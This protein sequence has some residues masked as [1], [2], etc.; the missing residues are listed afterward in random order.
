[1]YYLTDDDLRRTQ[2]DNQRLQEVAILGQP[3][4]VAVVEVVHTSQNADYNLKLYCEGWEMWMTATI[5]WRHTYDVSGHHTWNL[6]DAITLDEGT[7]IVLTSEKFEPLVDGGTL[8]NLRFR[9]EGPMSQHVA[10]KKFFF[11]D[12]SSRY[13]SNA[14]Q[15]LNFILPDDFYGLELLP[16]TCMP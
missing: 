9:F 15:E 4:G 8:G 3:K 6:F 14:A 11:N 13:A 5:Q 1:M 12:F 10:R 16:R 7:K 2:A